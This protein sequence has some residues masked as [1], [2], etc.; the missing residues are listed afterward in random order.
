MIL[1][2]IILVRAPKTTEMSKK[3]QMLTLY[4]SGTGNT[5]Y[6]AEL[7]SRK[8]G[9]S[10]ISIEAEA[11]F[12]Q[13]IQAHKTIAFCYPIYGS[14]VPRNMREFVAK[15]MSDLN[16]KKIIIFVTQM[17][18]SG[19]G[20]R[21]FT[22]MFWDDSIEVIYAEHF[23]MPNNVS[24]ILIFREPSR[25]KIQKYLINAE[26]KMSEVC[27]DIRKGIVKKRGFSFFSQILGNMQGKSWQG[28]S[29]EIYPGS[30]SIEFKAQTGV[31]IRKNCI[32]CNHCVNNCPV[33][34][35]ANVRGK[36]TQRGNCIVCYRCVNQCP[37][38]AITVMML[39][40][41]PRWQYKGVTAAVSDHLHK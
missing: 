22:D 5:K 6:I 41:R 14:R 18:F 20:A 16:G 40:I 28:N 39:N 36:I 31:K 12:V 25:K 8:M 9:A 24:N 1:H 10:C 17:L 15:Y 11:N 21:V 38:R 3:K 27:N 30:T 4:F 33:F 26:E 13:E 23:K 35:L 2:D 37:K 19:D 32:A 34:N 7:F 29:R